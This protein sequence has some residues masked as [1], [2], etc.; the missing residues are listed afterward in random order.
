MANGMII[1][2]RLPNHKVQSNVPSASQQ[3]AKDIMGQLNSKRDS[4]LV[5][6]A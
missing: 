1:N 4:T 6:N 5:M 3:V 2:R